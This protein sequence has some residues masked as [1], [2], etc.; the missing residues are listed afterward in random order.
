MLSFLAADAAIAEGPALFLTVTAGVF[1]AELGDKTQIAAL[2]L[3][4]GKGRSGLLGVFIGASLAL[5]VCTLLAVVAGAALQE[6]LT[7]PVR[8]SIAAGVFL[9]LGFRPLFE[10]AEDETA[11]EGGSGKRH[12]PLGLALSAFAP[13]LAAEMG[14]KTQF[15]TMSFAASY[16]LL[17]VFL[18]AATALVMSTAVAVLLGK[19]LSTRVSPTLLVRVGGMLFVAFGVHFIAHGG[20]DWGVLASAALG[21]WLLLWLVEQLK[22]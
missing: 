15:G 18:A 10:R 5:I 2:L 3:A 7:P 4:S 14:D 1:I 21:V 17:T 6:Y 20:D 16:D 8:N 9:L 11:S 22:G 12:S 19:W 13:V